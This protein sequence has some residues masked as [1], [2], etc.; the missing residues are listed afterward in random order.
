MM[1]PTARTTFARHLLLGHLFGYLPD[2]LVARSTVPA[3]SATSSISPSAQDVPGYQPGD[4]RRIFVAQHLNYT[5]TR[6]LTGASASVFLEGLLARSGQAALEQQ[7]IFQPLLS[8]A[9]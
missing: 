2:K 3:R 1:V 6:R 7:R 9:A 8:G 5:K 4:I